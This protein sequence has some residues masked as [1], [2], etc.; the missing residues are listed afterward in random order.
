MKIQPSLDSA[1]TPV[2]ELRRRIVDLAARIARQEQRVQTIKFTGTGPWEDM[3]AVLVDMVARRDAIQL[4]L[5]DIEAEPIEARP[6]RP[7]VPNLRL[8]PN[9]AGRAAPRRSC[10]TQ[11]GWH[12]AVFEGGVR[13]QKAHAR[14]PESVRPPLRVT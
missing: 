5:A 7:S 3:E 6:A 9:V 1:A 14:R 2:E 4:R 13:L 12:I 8:V 10:A 11:E